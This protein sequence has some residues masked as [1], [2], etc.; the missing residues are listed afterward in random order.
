MNNCVIPQKIANDIFVRHENG[1]KTTIHSNKLGLKFLNETATMVF[2]L[3]TGYNTIEYICDEMQSRFPDVS[4][5]I[6]RSDVEEIIYYL[7]DLGLISIDDFERPL[8]CDI[9]IA[10]NDDF[11]AIK[12]FVSNCLDD[13]KS[14]PA[15]SNLFVSRDKEWYNEYLL[16]ER[17][18]SF[19]EINLINVKEG[20]IHDMIT[21]VGV[22]FYNGT[23]NI[24]T[25]IHGGSLSDFAVFFQNVGTLL[26]E[27][28]IHKLKITLVD[29]I[30]EFQISDALGFELEAVLER[31]YKDKLV[32]VYRKFLPAGESI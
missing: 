1:G 29:G 24:G 16:R 28:S 15:S 3:C 10:R 26:R 21:L 6:I 27:I 4:S 19:G 8:G 9:R 23:A 30:H 13:D 22:A 5:D 2:D 25:L 31:E 20:K 7:R 32:L 14:Y 11:R 17:Q 12:N 18:F